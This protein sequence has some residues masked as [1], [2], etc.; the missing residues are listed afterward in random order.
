[1]NLSGLHLLFQR[2]RLR[3]SAYPEESLVLPYV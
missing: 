3:V 1:M 2:S